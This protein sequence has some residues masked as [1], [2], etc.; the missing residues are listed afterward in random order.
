MNRIDITGIDSLS[1]EEAK[2]V[3]Q[4]SE[5]NFEKMQKKLHNVTGMRIRINVNSKRSNN[6]K[7]GIISSIN[8]ESRKFEANAEDWKILKALN[9]A[10]TGLSNEI[11]HSLHI[12]GKMKQRANRKAYIS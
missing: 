8:M 7:F 3:L 10:L 1:P 5:K 4:I 9:A 2:K 12:S 11:E 6:K